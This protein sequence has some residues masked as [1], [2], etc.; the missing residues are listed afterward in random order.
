MHEY[1]LMLKAFLYLH[2]TVTSITQYAKLLRIRLYR[3]VQ[4]TFPCYI[5]L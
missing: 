4:W 2:V 5:A 1:F 3:H